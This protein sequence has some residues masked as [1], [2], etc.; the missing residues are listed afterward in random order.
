MWPATAFNPDSALDQVL[1]AVEPNL[2]TISPAVLSVLGIVGTST[3]MF[4]DVNLWVCSTELQSTGFPTAKLSGNMGTIGPPPPTVH[5]RRHFFALGEWRT[6]GGE[7]R[8]ALV[9]VPAAPHRSKNSHVAFAN[10]HRV[11]IVKGGLEFAESL[12][13]ARTGEGDW[14]LSMVGGGSGGASGQPLWKLVSGTMHR[15]ASSW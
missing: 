7:L 14:Q 13:A 2:N 10:G 5:A 9:A 1:P 3:L 4:L 11:V 6:A 12:V 8:C 15:R